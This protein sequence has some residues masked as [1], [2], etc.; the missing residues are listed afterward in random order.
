MLRGRLPEAGAGVA[1][2]GAFDWAL[3]EVL[4]DEGAAAMGRRP[5]ALLFVSVALF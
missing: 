2:L 5:V 4:D 3:K 1:K